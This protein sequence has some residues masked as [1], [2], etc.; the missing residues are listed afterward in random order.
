MKKQMRRRL[1][2]AISVAGLATLGLS[3][4]STADNVVLQVGSYQVTEGQLTATTDQVWEYM[5]I[6]TE[7]Y[8]KTQQELT[9]VA[10]KE[11]RRAQAEGSSDTISQAQARLVGQIEAANEVTTSMPSVNVT[12]N[13]LVVYGM[14]T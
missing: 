12:L 1:L 8:H 2:A 5:Q 13:L 10:I 6:A 3:A 9:D 14:L 4:C 11:M 7:S